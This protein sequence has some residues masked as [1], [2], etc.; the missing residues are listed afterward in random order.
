MAKH[1]RKAAAQAL[2]L[3]LAL[4][5]LTFGAGAYD[6]TLV[7]G[8]S[9]VGI[10]MDLG[11]V[12]VAGF[13]DVETGGGSVSPSRQ[14]GIMEGDIIF[15]VNGESVGSSA[16]FLA[17]AAEMDGS[18]ITLSVRRDSGEAD[19]AVTPAE[20][21]SGKMQLGLWLRDSVAGV[22]TLTYYDPETSA[23]GALGHGVSEID[24]GRLV[25]VDNGAVSD[26][27]I[28]DVVRGERGTPGE[29]CG[30]VADGRCGT[31]VRNTEAGIFGYLDGTYT[32][33][34]ALPVA[35]ESEVRLGEAAILANVS[36]TEVRQYA[37]EITRLYHDPDDCRGIM[38]TV[39][40][41]EL[42]GLTGGIVQGMS[43]SPII[44][45]GRLVGAVTHV[46]VND[47]TRGY[48]I[49]LEKMLDYSVDTLS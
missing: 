24:T 44:Q 47:P 42:L 14:A 30:S 20:N 41:P 48:G 4:L 35:D 21:E 27:E 12:M 46:L 11:G 25:P 18:A 15:A 6:G 33:G 39:T 45:D 28:V 49:Y 31:V 38:L 9:A 26:A 5:L 29:L 43:G 23:F 22:G 19:I 1:I 8:G 40:D 2:A 7:P 34:E 17:R 13:S 16:E 3:T 36:G 10:R 32:G 37:I